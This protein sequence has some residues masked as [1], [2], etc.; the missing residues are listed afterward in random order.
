MVNATVDLVGAVPICGTV[1]L[2]TEPFGFGGVAAE[3][4]VDRQIDLY[5]LFKQQLCTVSKG[6]QI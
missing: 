5:S 6:I 3:W 2:V 1:V 4:W